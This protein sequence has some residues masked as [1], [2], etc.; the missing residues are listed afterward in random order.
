[1]V[2][3][4]VGDVVEGVVSGIKD[5]GVF[6]V[7]NNQYSGLIHI[8][9]ISKYYV[10]NITDYVSVGEIILCEIVEINEK[11][12]QLKLSIKN[13]HYKLMPKSGKIKDTKGGFKQL[14]MNLPVWIR[15]KI[16][17]MDESMEKI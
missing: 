13:I 9:E 8:S 4:T 6:V 5:Y 1:M 2:N 14:Q 7:I 3:F 11:E 10:K 12:K 16:K 17:E 15:E